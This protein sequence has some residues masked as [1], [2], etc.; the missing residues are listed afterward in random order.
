MYDGRCRT[1]KTAKRRET[2]KQVLDCDVVQDGEVVN[3]E[4]DVAARVA[5]GA[6]ATKS[7]AKP[8]SS[9]L[10]PS[11]RLDVTKAHVLNVR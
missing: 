8:T 5:D 2:V 6:E 3:G 11:C 7:R 1:V 10:R 9:K 4:S